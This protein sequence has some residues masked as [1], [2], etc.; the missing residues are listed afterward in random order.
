VNLGS[1]LLGLAIA[2]GVKI[3][4][5]ILA[6]RLLLRLY[7][8]RHHSP[9]K[10][11]WLLL[12]E[13][14]IPHLRT[15]W[16]AL[17]LFALSELTCGIELYI[18]LRS[19]EVLSGFHSV[20]S[21]LAMGLFTL[22]LFLHFDR[23]L[24]RY[25]GSPC[26]LN[27]FCKGCTIAEEEG[28]K[29]RALFL[30]VATFAVLAAIPPLFASTARMDADPHR[31][32]LPFPAVEGW[33]SGTVIP[34]LKSVYPAYDPSGSAYY[35]PHSMFVIEFRLLPLAALCIGLFAVLR[36]WRRDELK[37]LHMVA[38]A[39]GILGYSYFE[40]VCYRVV[41]DALLGSLF[42]E[43]A[44][45]WFLVATAEFLVRSFHGPEHSGL[46]SAP[47]EPALELASPSQVKEET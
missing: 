16:W 28:C 1:A 21:G 9:V 34:W 25:G 46:P 20:V 36:I 4:V 18:L 42:H 35:L 7:A 40:I 31:F 3:L 14:E 17:V 32:L 27:R 30:M 23:K 10:K 19:N 26:L 38:L 15:L 2:L 29:Y 33:Y 6:A 11:L 37:G 8:A 43:A 24:F 39:A 44:E 13:D 12:P 22:G 5:M 41:G 45:L 47:M